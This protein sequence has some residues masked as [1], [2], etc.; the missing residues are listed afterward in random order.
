MTPA[1][2]KKILCVLV[3][4]GN[5]NGAVGKFLK[6]IEYNF[7]C[8]GCKWKW[9]ELAL[10]VHATDSSCIVGGSVYYH[11]SVCVLG[12]YLCMYIIMCI[13]VC[14]C[15]HVFVCVCVCMLYSVCVCMLYMYVRV[16]I[17]CV[18]YICV[19]MCM[20]TCLYVF[21]CMFM[22]VYK[23]VCVYTS[24]CVYIICLN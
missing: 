21:M 16:C 11:L 9:E 24:V 15:I 19:C 4:V 13:C 1:G 5:K 7:I 10:F 3:V 22:Y 23:Y 6:H 20:Y 8:G 2:R 12:V 14:V 17:L 18:L